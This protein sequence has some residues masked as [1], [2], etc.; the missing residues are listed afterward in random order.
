M[1]YSVIIVII[2]S[3]GIILGFIPTA[4]LSY[5]MFISAKKLCKKWEE[6][7]QKKKTE[8]EEADSE[9][10]VFTENAQNSVTDEA[11]RIK[12][13]SSIKKKIIR[14]VLII[15]IICAVCFGG[16]L[17]YIAY[18]NYKFEKEWKLNSYDFT[19]DFGALYRE[20]FRSGS[21]SMKWTSTTN[22]SFYD[23]LYFEDNYYVNVLTN[24]NNADVLEGGIYEVNGDI[25]MTKNEDGEITRYFLGDGY[26]V[27]SGEFFDGEAPKKDTF[28]ATFKYSYPDA[29]FSQITFKNDGT[30]I[31]K[32]N[33]DVYKGKYIRDGFIIECT[34]DDVM[35]SRNWLVCDGEITWRFYEDN[36]AGT[37]IEDRLKYE[38]YKKRGKKDDSFDLDYYRYVTKYEEEHPITFEE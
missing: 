4:I 7:K 12:N 9:V 15:F 13:K 36:I 27:S 34:A 37:Y 22:E 35:G 14:I 38:F 3:S 26:I 11:P 2:K 24:G 25:L 29:Y 28:D 30:Y 33:S 23:L 18:D 1:V 5:V 17:A 16:F 6:H 20:P 31:F 32:E 19:T 21:Y 8:I 10:E